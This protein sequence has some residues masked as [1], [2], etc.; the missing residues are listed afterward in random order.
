MSNGYDE[1]LAFGDAPRGQGGWLGAGTL[2]AL[3]ASRGAFRFKMGD[4]R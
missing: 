1:S 3:A 2:N 4:S